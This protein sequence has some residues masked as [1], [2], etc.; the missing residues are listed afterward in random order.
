LEIHDSNKEIAIKAARIINL[1]V[2]GIDIVADDI[3]RPFSQQCAAVIEVNAAP[4]LRMHLYPT[5][6]REKC[7]GRYS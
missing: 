1:D 4:G 7:S 6:D 5:K 3:S 2:A